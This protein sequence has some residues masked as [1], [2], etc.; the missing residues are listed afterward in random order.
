MNSNKIKSIQLNKFRGAVKPLEIR[1]DVQKSMVVILGENGTGKSTIVDAIDFLFNSE[2]GSLNE[3]SSTNIKTHVPSLGSSWKDMNIEASIGNLDYEKKYKFNASVS[4]NTKTEISVGILRRDKILKLINAPPQKRYESLKEFIDIPH[5]RACEKSLKGIANNINH[6][7][8]SQIK[9]SDDQIRNLENLWKGEGQPEEDFLLWA[10]NQS[11]KQD[12]ELKKKDEKYKKFIDF[13]QSFLDSWEFLKKSNQGLSQTEEKLNLIKQ[14]LGQEKDQNQSHE[15]IDILQKT[16]SFLEKKRSQNSRVD[17]CLVCEQFIESESLK[18]KISI[19]LESMQK[20]VHINKQYQ[21]S[22][23]EHKIKERIFLENKR[24]FINLIKKFISFFDKKSSVSELNEV[25]EEIKSYFEKNLFIKTDINFFINLKKENL[26]S[27]A[28]NN[29]IKEMEK[30]E[31][32][33]QILLDYPVNLEK[34]EIFFKNVNLIFQKTVDLCEINAKTLHQL[35]LIKTTYVNFKKTQKKIEQLSDK[36]A[37]F[38]N[39]LK[40][41]EKERKRYVENVLNSISRDVEN[42]YLRFHPEEGFNAINLTLVPRRQSSLEIKA[43]FQSEENV[44]PQAYFSD[45]HLDTLGICIF[46]AMAKYFKNNVIILDDVLASVDQSHINRF[47]N[48]AF[49]ENKHFNQII[50]TTHSK[51]L[52]EKYKFPCK[53]DVSIQFIE[54]SPFWSLEQGIKIQPVSSES[55]LG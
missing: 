2:C 33:S 38:K 7:L 3:K 29:K 28:E 50:F 32:N 15:I 44:P 16:V 27:K 24:N 42:L 47:M 6:D 10:Q 23:D 30:K 35:S 21:I 34:A 46:L 49:D 17:K 9:S 13:I 11:Q 36:E 31:I 4:Q 19:R 53:T 20:L 18:T 54:L 22:K 45:S 37:F 51:A 25:F 43:D 39:V 40:I 26:I 14:Q 48:I 41:V 12:F 1:F 52:Y 55:Q 8:K 5:I